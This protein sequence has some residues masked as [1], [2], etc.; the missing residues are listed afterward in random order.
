MSKKF[1]GNDRDE[2]ILGGWISH[3][4]TTCAVMCECGYEFNRMISDWNIE[5][6]PTCGKGYKVE[7]VVWQYDENEL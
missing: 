4:D 1:A 6:C 7:F 5:R 3:E 2:S